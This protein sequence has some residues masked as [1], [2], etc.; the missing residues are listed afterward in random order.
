ML[1]QTTS[2]PNIAQILGL[3]ITFQSP[4][5]PLQAVFFLLFP[6]HNFKAKAEYQ[7]LAADSCLILLEVMNKQLD[8]PPHK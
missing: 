8:C 1:T 2:I 6:L 4:K 3:E 5:F 7:Q